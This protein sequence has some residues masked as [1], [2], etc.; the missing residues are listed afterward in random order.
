VVLERHEIDVFIT[1]AEELHFG[2]TAERLD[3][4]TA[5]VSQTVARLERRIGVPLFHRT[6][7]RVELSSVGRRLLDDVKPAWSRITE[8]VTRAIDAGRGLHGEVRAAFVGAAAAQ[9]LVG[10]ADLFHRAFPASV[11]HLREAQP[12]E[13]AD[14]LLTE[15]A[16]VV[17]AVLPVPHSEI[18]AGP[19]LIREAR[20]LALPV[21]H[22]FARRETLS[23]ADVARVP[24]IAPGPEAR[25]VHEILTQVGLGRGA[26]EI[27]AH[28]RRYYDRPDVAYV[29]I[30][31]APLLEW[32]LMWRTGSDSARVHGFGRLA[33]DLLGAAA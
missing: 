12:W 26:Y 15:Q 33:R 22:P 13:V 7:R 31:D 17:L 3:I 25:T 5:R 4:S 10:T 23:A 18:S 19:V 8:A 29:P 2:R 9:V 24:L 28:A 16:D 1:L 11:V 14:L 30:S 21:S 27:G 32:A 6:S 20:M